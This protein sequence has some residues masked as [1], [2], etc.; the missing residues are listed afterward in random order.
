MNL[1]QI[2]DAGEK[3]LGPNT[4]KGL[5]LTGAQITALAGKPDAT[6]SILREAVAAGYRA[7]NPVEPGEILALTVDSYRNREPKR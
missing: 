1:T 4:M 7:N 6:E 3:V 5:Y 2:L